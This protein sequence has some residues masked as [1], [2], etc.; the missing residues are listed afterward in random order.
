MALMW[1]SNAEVLYDVA[2]PLHPRAVC[3]ISNTYARIFNGTSVDFLVPNKDGTTALVN[4][5]LGSNTE[6]LEAR[7]PADLTNVYL[8][9]QFAELS[10]PPA[11]GAIA[12]AASG[13][14][15]ANGSSVVDVRVANLDGNTKVFSYSVGGIDSFGRP[16]LPSP[17]LALSADGTYLVAGWAIEGI[18]V[19]LFRLNDRAEVSLPLPAGLRFGFWSRAGHT[20]YLVGA[21]GVEAWSPE[22]GAI[23]LQGAEAW[24]LGPN[25]SPDGTQVAYTGFTSTH[26]IR[27]YTYDFKAKATHLLVDQPR[28]SV[29]FVKAGWVWYMEE[30]PCVQ[31]E[32]NVCFDSTTPDGNVLALE[33]ATG[34]ESPVVFAPGESLTQPNTFSVAPVDVWPLG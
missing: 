8:G 16:G 2:D 32:S 18:G 30:K 5:A 1:G 7:F 9:S 29:V 19:H 24:T 28:S 10:R 17:N 4:H 21:S 13:G 26:D 23:N 15:D 27:S 20:L 14:T 22:V 11:L 33:L 31:T 34:R 6:V 12:Y 25:F 3:R